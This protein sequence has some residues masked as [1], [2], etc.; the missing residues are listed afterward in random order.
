MVDPLKKLLTP[1][2]QVQ[3]IRGV[4]LPI[5][6]EFLQLVVTG[7]P[8]AGKSFYIE[9]IGGW[10]NEGYLDLTQKGWW[11]DQSLIYRPREVHLGLPFRGF[12]EALTVF[13][14]EWLTSIDRLELDLDR[15]ILPPI[16]TKFYQT[17]WRS[18]YIFEFLIPSA[19]K[20]YEQRAGRKKKG[21]FPIDEDLDLNQVKLQVA[22]YRE[23]AL[24]LS[25]GGLNVYIRKGLDKK[26][27]RIAEK[28]S[29]IVPDWALDHPKNE[30]INISSL[31]D[32]KYLFRKKYPIKWLTLTDI[33]QEL[34]AAA[35]IAHDGKS[36][37]LRIGQ[38]TLRV[39]PEIAL[40]VK[41]KAAHKNWTISS[42]QGCSTRAIN[43]FM[44]VQVGETVVI[45]HD[46]PEYADLFDF[47]DT[48]AKRHISISNRR[49]DLV[50]APL[51]VDKKSKVARL[52]ELDHREQI[53]T[54]R[55]K[56]L[57]DIRNIYGQEIVPLVP[58]KALETI[59]TVNEL[60]LK[61]PYRALN[62]DGKPGGLVEVPA[63]TTPVIV[64]DLHAQVDNLLKILTENCLLDC[65]RMK[66]ATLILLGDTI[67]SEVSG[68]MD[69]FD[70]SMLMLD[71][72]FMLKIR[73]PKNFF[74]LRGN[75]ESFSP[76]ISK[77]G[78]L[79]G[80]IFKEILVEYRGNDYANEVQ[81]F[82][83]SLPYLVCSDDFIACHAGPPRWETTKDE[84][85]NISNN[86]KLINEL[87][88][89][90]LS[91]PNHLAGY[92]KGDVKRLRKALGQSSKCRLIVGHSPMDPF[93]SHWMNVG[94]IKQHHVIYSGHS[95]GPSVIIRSRK[96]FMPVSFPAEPLTDLINNL[97]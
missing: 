97:K 59:R 72:L 46:N 34:N 42:K 63:T 68:E 21:Y 49:G 44:R 18:R 76:E 62:T 52:D 86:E 65:L 37:E 69:S 16:K 50:L 67:H 93:G 79:Q 20:I 27:M 51:S 64:G 96:N 80:E 43:G 48:V 60:M 70:S 73:F 6:L 77:N 91:Q 40:G 3:E 87:T 88:H 4:F 55:Y 39:L 35:R 17:D 54:G 53:E 81:R 30:K 25:R 75:H 32:L 13:D 2:K 22:A 7:P 31:H 47:D 19:N 95:R 66:T 29:A 94:G 84:L 23:V 15:I 56:A 57:L 89:N 38:I 61:E 41:K 74:Y 26:P 24:Y 83:N 78:F 90:R 5:G 1:I 10:P 58:H 92:S 33:P 28:G 9:Q 82:F 85:V 11:K 36:F 45:G 12:A 14:K 8:G 71:I